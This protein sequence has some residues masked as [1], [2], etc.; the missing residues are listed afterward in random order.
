MTDGLYVL[1]K[2]GKPAI[3][4]INIK[5]LE[6]M[7]GSGTETKSENNHPAGNHPHISPKPNLVPKPVETTPPPKT[8]EK[9]LPVFEPQ[10][11][12]LVSKSSFEVPRPTVTPT[13]SP[14]L[15]AP[16][17]I[18]N[19]DV[20]P[21][22]NPT[23]TG[24]AP[25]SQPL[26]IN[27]EQKPQS[28]PPIA[29]AERSAPTSQIPTKPPVNP[30]PIIPPRQQPP[31]SPLTTN[32]Q[33][34]PPSS[35]VNPVSPNDAYPKMVAPPPPPPPSPLPRIPSSFQSVPVPI[36][37][38]KGQ[39]AASSLAPSQNMSS[40]PTV[41]LEASSQMPG[42]SLPPPP[43]V[44]A[45]APFSQSAPQSVVATPKPVE[46]IP[47]DQPPTT[48]PEPGEDLPIQPS[49]VSSQ[50]PANISSPAVSRQP[51]ADSPAPAAATPPQ[52][53]SSVQDLEI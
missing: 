19:Y 33:S 43:V 7:M 45:P 4:L 11:P 14:A 21:T 23:W 17:P 39:L 6:E 8:P 5:Y 48:I 32:P 31:A 50:L 42:A 51:Q 52:S 10:K 27:Q 40:N 18:S 15:G 35:A 36:N 38:S 3:A 12:P 24:E 2:G 37:G 20:K 49:A 25:P 1:T 28:L 44:S 53:Q 41:K 46:T 16:K 30:W 26:A 22:V 47:F 34:L 29:Q 9:P 13:P